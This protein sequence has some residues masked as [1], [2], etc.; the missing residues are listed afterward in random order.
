MCLNEKRAAFLRGE[1]DV[2]KE[3]EKEF[4]RKV[5]TAKIDFKNK[6]DEILALEAK[7]V[8]EMY[9]DD[10]IMLKNKQD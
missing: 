2:L 5:F 1:T 10:L 6:R 8:K 3:K 4:K 7:D 9:M